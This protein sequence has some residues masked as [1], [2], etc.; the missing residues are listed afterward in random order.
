VA[1]TLT[2]ENL[3]IR[4]KW[5]L[6]GSLPGEPLEPVELGIG[7]PMTGLYLREDVE[8][9][10]SVVM[11]GFVKK[12]IKK[13]H[14][15]LL[16]RVKAH[17]ARRSSRIGGGSHHVNAPSG[18]DVPVP[19]GARPMSMVDFKY[20]P[21]QPPPAY[22]YPAYDLPAD[23]K[24][25]LAVPAAA[26][27]PHR[28]SCPP[29]MDAV[30]PP[31]PHMANAPARPM[32]RPSYEQQVNLSGP[33]RPQMIRQSSSHD[34]AFAARAANAR[35][36]SYSSVAVA[37][38][39]TAYA[40]PK[41]GMPPTT[42][43]QNPR[44]ADPRQP[45]MYPEP[46]R[47]RHTSTASTVTASSLLHEEAKAAPPQRQQQRQQ[48]QQHTG[49]QQQPVSYASYGL[50]HPDYPHL[51]PYASEDQDADNQQEQHDGGADDDVW[52]A[53]FAGKSRQAAGG[54]PP[55]G[56]AEP[57][58]N[59]EARRYNLQD[60]GAGATLAGPFVAELE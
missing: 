52:Q 21:A 2:V 36:H 35:Q 30:A 34:D 45:N 40:V 20:A 4:A 46:L 19:L 26:S 27:N 59:G 16:D 37:A 8:L 39:A 32:E 56:Q 3:D 55:P 18:L 23:R 5:T 6:N 58:V 31:P 24:S 42:Q 25:S 41:L 29:M 51:N 33:H 54:V 48:Q 7:A 57:R 50:Q 11:A 38:G 1:Y 12:T 53:F 28:R 43:L 9:R 22:P 15:T 13:S 60:P 49:R 17:A 44:E 47:L 10:V 14:H